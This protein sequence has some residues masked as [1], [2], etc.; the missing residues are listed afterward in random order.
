MKQQFVVIV[1]D[2]CRASRPMFI[3]VI[4]SLFLQGG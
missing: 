1:N 2:S 3:G 4:L